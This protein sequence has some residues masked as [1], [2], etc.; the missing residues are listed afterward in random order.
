MTNRSPPPVLSAYGAAL[1]GVFLASESF[2]RFRKSDG[3]VTAPA[4]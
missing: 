3:P 1:S 2:A 4:R